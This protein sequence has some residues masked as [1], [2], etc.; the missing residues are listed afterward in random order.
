MFDDDRSG[1]L[2][3]DLPSWH[4]GDDV[5]DDSEAMAEMMEI[6]EVAV[7]AVAVPKTASPLYTMLGGAL[8]LFGLG[9]A[10]TY[11]RRTARS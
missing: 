1:W 5:L 3:D 7:A 6:E 8:A 2:G 11:R 4:D 9:A 10:L